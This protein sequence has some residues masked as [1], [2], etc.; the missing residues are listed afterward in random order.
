MRGQVRFIR[1][2]FD[3][4]NTI[5]AKAVATD[6]VMIILVNIHILKETLPP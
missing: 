3:D 2:N 5:Q 1:F 6:V 4:L